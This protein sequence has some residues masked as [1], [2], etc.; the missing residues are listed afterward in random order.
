MNKYHMFWTGFLK[1]VLYTLE[2]IRGAML[3]IGKQCFLITLIGVEGQT[4]LLFQRKSSIDY[5]KER[6]FLLKVEIYLLIVLK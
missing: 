2:E 4:N 6:K 5:G 3:E 1:T